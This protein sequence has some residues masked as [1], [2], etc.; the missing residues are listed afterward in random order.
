M[1]ALASVFLVVQPAISDKQPIRIGTLSTLDSARGVTRS[2][3]AASSRHRWQP[4][5]LVTHSRHAA[6]IHFPKSSEPSLARR[7][8]GAMLEYH[9]HFSDWFNAFS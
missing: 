4:V 3:L 8:A 6:A 9:C 1:A 7:H 2:A 5:D